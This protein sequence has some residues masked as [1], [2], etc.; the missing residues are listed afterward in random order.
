MH[1]F[2]LSH[3]SEKHVAERS[4]RLSLQSLFINWGTQLFLDS[5]WLNH[6]RLF[7]SDPTSCSWIF[8]QRKR[9]CIVFLWH[10]ILSKISKITVTCLKSQKQTSRVNFGLPKDSKITNNFKLLN[11]SKI[12]SF[13][14]YI[15]P[16]IGKL[17]TSNLDSR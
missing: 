12:T 6:W 13:K 4:K 2:I 11:V 9:V 3:K 16:V 8:C 5:C 14:I 7:V 1:Y 10:N 17:E 15:F